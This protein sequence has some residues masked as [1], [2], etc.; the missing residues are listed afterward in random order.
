MIVGVVVGLS[1]LWIGQTGAASLDER[2]A[3][4]EK[5]MSAGA[6]EQAYDTFSAVF[7][8]YPDNERVNMALGQAAFAAKK[9]PHAAMAYERV[10]M[11]N[12]GND[13][14]RAELA[15]AYFE[16]RQYE[17]AREEFETIL[18][19]PL[20]ASVR[21]NIEQFLARIKSQTKRGDVWGRLNVS[22]TYD[23]NANYGPDVTL[24][25]TSLGLLLLDESATAQEAWGAAA[26]ASGGGYYDVGAPGAW[27]AIGDVGAYATWLDNVTD[28][29][30][31]LVRAGGGAQH[32]GGRALFQAPAAFQYL[33]RGH[34]PYLEV[35]SARP[36]VLYVLSER[37]QNIAA[38]PLEARDYDG[39]TDR[40]G[41]YVALEETLKRL[42]GDDRR[43]SLALG[44]VVFLE[45]TK[46]EVWS[47]DG[48]EANLAGECRLPWRVSASVRVRYRDTDYDEAGALELEPRRDRQWQG[49]MGAS[50]AIGKRWSLDA[51]YQY[52]DTDSTFDLYTYTRNTITLGMT[53]SF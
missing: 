30:L 40:D 32:V 17:L 22:A 12:A 3:E 15:R 42:L 41:S 24:V 31:T 46:D 8:D 23:D 50:K 20:P 13:R 49:T 37:W 39:R 43:C 1:S 38:L 27:S 2:L 25:D 36:T 14:A 18:T 44:G 26:T 29:E 16:M 7:K 34:D 33:E 35:Y 5:A 6:Y 19:H 45:D 53:V 9:Y 51:A 21:Q 4:G 52:T 11:L 28:Q 47:N 10:L 48:W